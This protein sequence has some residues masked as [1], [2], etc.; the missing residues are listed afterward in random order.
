MYVMDSVSS[1]LVTRYAVVDTK[2]R[3]RIKLRVAVIEEWVYLCLGNINLLLQNNRSSSVD[4]HSHLRRAAKASI[5]SIM[6]DPWTAGVIKTN[7][8]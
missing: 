7:M 4:I 2:K 6:K 1:E 3:K 8:G 5:A